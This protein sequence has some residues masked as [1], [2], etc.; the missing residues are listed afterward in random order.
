MCSWPNPK[1]PNTKNSRQPGFPKNA[2][3]VLVYEALDG[4]NRDFE[5]V[6][7]NLERLATLDLFTKRW[8]RKF[9]KEWRATL[10]RDPSLGQL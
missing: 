4:F 10:E 2:S 6:L 8:Q 7:E 1:K 9:L 5:Q 3:K